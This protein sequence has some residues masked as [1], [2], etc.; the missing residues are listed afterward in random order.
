MTRPQ[1]I[2]TFARRAG[3]QVRAA[4]WQA[5]EGNTATAVMWL[6]L[7]SKSL[8]EL[9]VLLAEKPISRA[10]L[11][12]VDEEAPEADELPRSTRERY[13]PNWPRCACGDFTLD[14]HL[15]CGRTECGTQAEAERRR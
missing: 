11:S 1:D 15:T 8:A 4:L 3:S 9:D 14:G 6:D 2:A 10:L 13:P 7:A 12:L 5:R